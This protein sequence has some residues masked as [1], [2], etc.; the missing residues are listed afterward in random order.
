MPRVSG[1]FAI[2]RRSKENKSFILTIN[3]E[4][5][6]PPEMCQKWQRR[7][8]AYLP[9]ELVAFR[10]PTSKIAAENGAKALIELLKKEVSMGKVS[11]QIQCLTPFAL[12]VIQQILS[13]SF[14][15]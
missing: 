3:L 15:H 14:F 7:S 1:D 9:A 8:F 10:Y 6:L 5:G 4:S 11:R 13:L 12:L 2:Q